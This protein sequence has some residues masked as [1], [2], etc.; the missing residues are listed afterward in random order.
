MAT[1][2]SGSRPWVLAATILGSSMAFIDGSVVNVAL[3]AIQADLSAS[4]SATQWVVNAYMLMLSALLLVGG[5]AGDL[6]GR[7]RI[8]AAGLALFTVA[9][10]GCG[11]APSA[12]ALIAGRALQGVG[13]AL[14]VPTSLAIISA[15]FP[16]DERG[17][18]IGTWAGF[19][20]LTTAMGPVF[21]GWLVDTWGWRPIF[22]VNVPIGA[23]SLWLAL[24]RVPESRSEETGPIDWVGGLLA[25]AG[26]GALVHGL[27]AAAELD[28][29]TLSVLGSLMGGVL[30]LALFVRHE[31]RTASPLV[32]LRL[33][34]SRPFSGANVLTLLLYFALG[35]AM[36]FL[37]FN[38]IRV[39]GYSAASA[40]AAFLPFTLLMGLLSRWSGSL[41]ERFGARRMLVTGPVLAAAG[42]ALLARPGIGG[43]YWSTFF[44]GMAVLGLGM[45]VSVAPLTTAVMGAV[46]DR[47]AGSASGVNNAVARL[48]G[49]LAVAV[50]GTV[51]VGVYRGRIERGLTEL[52][53]GGDLRVA[54]VR[55]ASRLAEAR[56]PETASPAVRQTLERLLR[57]SFV[58]SYRVV[59]LVAAALALAAAVCAAVTIAGRR[60]APER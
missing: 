34:R 44:P 8:F 20:A 31:A 46:P 18:A 55:E 23:V 25:A 2:S 56:V 45:A 14:L 15:A 28:W 33:F 36:F 30:I 57:E 54:M 32:S 52:Q 22:F 4:V 29:T 27:T 24:S 35:G 19:S 41:V 58:S 13:G 5:A 9:S 3:P 43:S 7:R 47:F 59:M 53:V 11:L 60:A 42:F 6:V 17:R 1:H 16:P 40:G 51:A 39:Q 49:M 38:L 26:L 10:V 12:G 50:L 21:G 37:P 48:A